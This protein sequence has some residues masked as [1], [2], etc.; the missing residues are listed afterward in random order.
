MLSS[1]AL[2]LFNLSA[3]SS[4]VQAGR[5]TTVTALVLSGPDGGAL[6]G[7]S[8]HALRKGTNL[9]ATPVKSASA[10]LGEQMTKVKD[11]LKAGVDALGETLRSA[12]VDAIDRGEIVFDRDASFWDMKALA[13]QDGALPDGLRAMAISYDQ[14]Q[15]SV[16]RLEVEGAKIQIAFAE[17]E[18]KAAQAEY[19]RL[20]EQ[21]IN[22]LATAKLVSDVASDGT[23]NGART[24][25]MLIEAIRE[26]QGL[27]AIGDSAADSGAM[28]E[29][30]DK[31]RAL[32]LQARH[33]VLVNEI[34]GMVERGE[35]SIGMVSETYWG[36]VDAS[37]EAPAG[38]AVMIY[39][40]QKDIVTAVS[41][42]ASLSGGWS[43]AF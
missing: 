9:D 43:V 13:D 41:V 31:T 4:A 10:L 15:T 7:D 23:S 2:S 24:A 17:K 27:G 32:A 36:E 19:N 14:A 37:A 30:K 5:V 20:V 21:A 39:Q 8:L 40:Q 18:F 34:R 1:P 35:L 16:L 28:A 25:L 6:R 26:K 29:I 38:G 33:G 42:S 22:D 3:Q 12:W 11:Q